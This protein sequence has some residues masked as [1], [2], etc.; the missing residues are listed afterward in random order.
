M[1]QIF[2]LQRLITLSAA[3]VVMM[4]AS[5]TVW[6]DPIVITTGNPG[7]QNTDNVLFNN[8]A[9]T[10]SGLVVQGDFNG[11]GAGFIVDFTSTS[12]SGNLGVSGGQAVLVGGTGNTPFTNVTVQLENGATFQKLILN[13]D[14]TNGLAPPNQ[15]Q[16]TVNYT[17]LGG[18]VFNQVFTVDANGQNFF[19]IEAFEGAVIN[20]VT[21]QALGNTTFADINQWRLGGLSGPPQT[22][23]P[24]PASLLLLGSGLVGTAGALRRRLKNRSNKQD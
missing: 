3:L 22:E 4:M 9:L 7:N 18:Q 6:A 10:H 11:S 1:P 23:V 17:L 20:S 12:G 19:G 16:F 13:I 2:N 21:I 8:P 14:V 5:A 24:E 15:V